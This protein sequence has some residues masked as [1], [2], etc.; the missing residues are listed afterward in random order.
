VTKESHSEGTFKFNQDFEHVSSS[1]FI[2]LRR[3]YKVIYGDLYPST[4][5]LFLIGPAS[6][7]VM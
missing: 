6:F 4:T 7:P 3:K 5:E 2:V 1:K